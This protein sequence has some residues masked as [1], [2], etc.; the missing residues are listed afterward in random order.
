MRG[1]AVGGLRRCG[2]SLGGAAGAGEC[3]VAESE[4]HR[5]LALRLHL[6]GI[7]TEASDFRQDS[8]S[9]P[10]QQQHR[11]T[12]WWR[13]SSNAQHKSDK[14][15]A[16]QPASKPASRIAQAGLTAADSSRRRKQSSATADL[17][18]AR[19][20]QWTAGSFCIS[21]PSRL[22]CQGQRTEERK[23]ITDVCKPGIMQEKSK[24]KVWP[25][26]AAEQFSW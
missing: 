20:E 7:K 6:S 9:I 2:G 25:G 24:H 11:H 19:T 13:T 4:G 3:A 14:Q 10:L 17:F 18:S 22:D 12:G 16:S 1:A 21:W 23:W 5:R 15:S 26:S 8:I